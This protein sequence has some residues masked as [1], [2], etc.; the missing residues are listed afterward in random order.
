MLCRMEHKRWAVTFCMAGW[1]AGERNDAIRK[2][3]NLVT[4]DELKEGTRNYDLE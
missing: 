1:V 4:Y 2:H 3:L